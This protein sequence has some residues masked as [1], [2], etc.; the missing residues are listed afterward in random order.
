MHQLKWYDSNGTIPDD[1]GVQ[2]EVT[3]DG[4]TD[5]WKVNGM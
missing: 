2:K 5:Q 1:Y 3:P 4:N